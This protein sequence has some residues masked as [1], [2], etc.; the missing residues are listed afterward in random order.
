MAKDII[1]KYDYELPIISNQKMNAYL[2]EI[3]DVCGISKNLHSHLA[4]KTYA[5]L[6][7]NRGVAIEAVSKTLGHSNIRITQE[8]YAHLLNKTII[9]EVLSKI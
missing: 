1:L 6:L 9:D 2:K 7:L 8:C 3:A 5:T 4:R